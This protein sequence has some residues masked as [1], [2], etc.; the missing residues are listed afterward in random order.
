MKKI[1]FLFLSI[2]LWANEHMAKIEPFEIYSIKADV[3]AKVVKSRL[4]LEAKVVENEQVIALDSYI[5]KKSLKNLESKLKNLK[6]M[7][8]AEKETLKNLEKLVKIK[9]ENYERVKDLKTKSKFE[10]DMK[11]SD[12]LTTNS[13]YLAQISKIENLKNQIEDV[14][15]NIEKIKDI[16]KK[17]SIKV[18]GYIYNIYVKEGDFVNPGAKLL[19]VADISKGKIV[20]Y[21][22]KEEIENLKDKKI[23]INGKKT[24]LKFYKIH[25]IADPVHISAYKAEILIDSPKIFSKII[26]VEIK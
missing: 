15:L 5:D 14:R 7:L 21:L 10:K 19:D 4:E 16:L 11:L 26:K 12:Y 25:K 17:K 1:Y 24:N 18:S 20:I 2:I 22:D 9:K 8:I 3:G 6:N 13:Q 23:Y